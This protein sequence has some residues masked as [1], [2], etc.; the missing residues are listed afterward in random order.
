MDGQWDIFQLPCFNKITRVAID[1][2][3][4]DDQIRNEDSRNGHKFPRCWGEN[5]T[6]NFQHMRI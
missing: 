5:T 2:H 1:D 3:G 6:F 4:R